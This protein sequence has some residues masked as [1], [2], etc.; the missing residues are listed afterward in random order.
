MAT[1]KVSYDY[2]PYASNESNFIKAERHYLGSNDPD[3][4]VITPLL[5]PFFAKD[6]IIRHVGTGKELVKGKDYRLEHEITDWRAIATASLYHLI[7]IINKDLYGQLELDYRTVGSNLVSTSKQVLQLLAETRANPIRTPYDRL[8]EVPT[9]FPT[10]QHTQHWNDFTNKKYLAETIDA[11]TVS[12]KA[13]DAN[14]S[15]IAVKDLLDRIAAMNTKLNKYAQA[16]HIAN[17][18]N[19]HGL[20]PEDVQALSRDASAVKSLIGYSK[21]LSEL[22]EYINS[23]GITQ[24]DIDKYLFKT[25]HQTYKDALVLSD[26]NAVICNGDSSTV[27]DLANGTASITTDGPLSL[28]ADLGWTG[29]GSVR[30]IAGNNELT[31]E[32]DDADGYKLKFNGYEVLTVKNAREKLAGAGGQGMRVVTKD[33]DTV[34]WEGN[35]RGDSPLKPTFR[36][37]LATESAK[38]G[39]KLTSNVNSNSKTLV[40]TPYIVNKIREGLDGYV[41]R[42]TTINGQPLSSNV[43]ITKSDVGFDKVDNTSDLD[44]PITDAQRDLLAGYSDIGH[45]HDASKMALTHATNDSTGV[46]RYVVENAGGTLDGEV[47]V[48]SVL[49]DIASGLVDVETESK[50]KMPLDVL[51]LRYY[52]ANADITIDGFKITLPRSPSLVLNGL[53][54]SASSEHTIDEAVI[55]LSGEFD[56]PTYKDIYIY[57]TAESYDSVKYSVSLTKETNIG[58]TMLIAHIRTNSTTVANMTEA[59]GNDYHDYSDN[60]DGVLVMDSVTSVGAFRDLEE[61]ESA[62]VPHPNFK[63]FNKEDIGLDLVGDY[64]QSI[65]VSSFSHLAMR[66]WLTADNFSGD[67]ALTK[68][69]YTFTD[70]MEKINGVNVCVGT[71]VTANPVDAATH[72]MLINPN[73]K[74]NDP[75][76]Y[77]KYDIDGSELE[78]PHRIVCY[79]TEPSTTNS[80]REMQWALCVLG[81]WTSSNG[82]FYTLVVNFGDLRYPPTSAQ[83]ANLVLYKN[84]VADT[85][86]ASVSIPASA[87]VD[88]D[89]T[90]IYLRMSSKVVDGVTIYRMEWQRDAYV[91][92][93]LADAVAF[94]LHV[95]EDYQWYCSFD[96]TTIKESEATKTTHGTTSKTTMSTLMK[97]CYTSGAVGLGGRIEGASGAGLPFQF[98]VDCICAVEGG[99]DERYISAQAAYDALTHDAGMLVQTG[100]VSSGTV[101]PKYSRGHYTQYFLGDASFGDVTRVYLGKKINQIVT[102]IRNLDSG[103][104]NGMADNTTFARHVK[105]QGQVE[106]PNY[107]DM[108]NG[109]AISEPRRNASPFWNYVGYSTPTLTLDGTHRLIKHPGIDHY[110]ATNENRAAWYVRRRAWLDKG[111]HSIWCDA[112]DIGYLYIDGVEKASF[113]LGGTSNATLVID[114]SK[115]Y[116]VMFIIYNTTRISWLKLDEATAKLFGGDVNWYSKLIGRIG[117]NTISDSSFQNVYNDRAM[118]ANRITDERINYATG[119]YLYIWIARKEIIFPAGEVTVNLACD[120]G[121]SMYLDNTLVGTGNSTN[122][123][124]TFTVTEGVHQITCIC[125]QATGPTWLQATLTYGGATHG[126]D[127]TWY[128]TIGVTRTSSKYSNYLPNPSLIDTTTNYMSL[129]PRDM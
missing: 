68:G 67:Y 53:N 102:A 106:V 54:F 27:I 97:N 78:T 28:D 40:A 61:H 85:T 121:V 81:Y 14:N 84:F 46:V 70:I 79:R 34:T 120:D 69:T 19:P 91:A 8:L 39:V 52:S 42:T 35:S 9:A 66:Q 99:Q 2:D 37:K 10:F 82:D 16:A 18:S 75:T 44:K 92:K 59:L 13:A 125:I 105:Y 96:T 129:T 26:G 48:P 119:Y 118:F 90:D 116:D 7:K 72:F 65:G 63:G 71:K 128:T 95:T 43:N 36:V 127:T 94:E 117:G 87:Y 103:G 100:E 11:L 104:Y 15:D 51:D 12:V 57:V 25:T 1:V 41:K 112:D 49:S 45:K 73:A 77:V 58:S 55:D 29:K 101:L 6:L 83:T 80:I 5:A 47:T 98:S 32:E 109:E 3:T 114:E 64:D 110:G 31:I 20:S 108:I 93:G 24:T 21:S 123:T 122:S 33:T 30:I 62:E 89:I 74:F 22:A 124:F 23:R 86:L 50:G 76:Y 126:L 60:V 107:P 111:T 38:G 115:L 17:K 56:D 88:T 4:R 113:R